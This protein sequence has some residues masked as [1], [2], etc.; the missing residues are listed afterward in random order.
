MRMRVCVCVCAYEFASVRVCGCLRVS[1]SLCMCI[2]MCARACAY[3]CVWLCMRL[4][5][6]ARVRVF[7]A[8]SGACVRAWVWVWVC[9]CVRVR[10]TVCAPRRLCGRCG[11][12]AGTGRIDS[13]ARGACGRA[14]LLALVPIARALRPQV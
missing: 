1:G 3:A 12:T 2:R 5:L 10:L 11:G 6:W 9:V 8:L 7:S 13:S 4:G 14:G